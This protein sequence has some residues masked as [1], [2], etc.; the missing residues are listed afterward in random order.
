MGTKT[1]TSIETTGVTSF[2]DFQAGEF[3]LYLVPIKMISF[4]AEAKQ[5]TTVL[6]WIT[7]DEQMVDYFEI[8]R[9]SDGFNFQTI[10]RVPAFNSLPS[11]RYR[12]EDRAVLI[13]A[14][15]RVMTVGFDGR[16][17]YSNHLLV[18]KQPLQK[19]HLAAQG[20]DGQALL[21]FNRSQHS[22]AFRYRLW[23]TN[24]GRVLN[25]T[26]VL[27]ANSTVSIPTYHLASG[28]YIIELSNK[29]ILF[30]QKLYIGL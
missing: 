2:S 5:G 3:T 27:G 16:Y 25:G 10:G 4:T 11:F 21:V 14:Y 8:Q 19:A 29:E 26:I 6:S 28:M 1:A 30:K 12:F 15:Y 24:G 23:T 18:K 13:D 22:G 9:S 17:G 7:A 20:S